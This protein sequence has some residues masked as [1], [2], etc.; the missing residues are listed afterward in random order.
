MNRFTKKFQYSRITSLIFLALFCMMLAPVESRAA[1]LTISPSSAS[2]AIGRSVQFSVAGPGSANVVWSVNGVAGGNATLGTISSSGLYAAPATVPSPAT[3]TI[4]AASANNSGR[5]GQAA[6]TI[7]PGITISISPVNPSVGVSQT[8]QFTATVSGSSNV[9]VIWSVNDVAGGNSTAGTISSSG[10]YTAPATVPSGSVAVTA[11]SAADPTNSTQVSVTVLPA[12]SV[13]I[14]PTSASVGLSQT[15]QFTASVTGS[16]NTTVTWSVNGTA[17][18]NTT[19]G[20]ISSSGLYTAPATMPSS[21]SVTVAATS[22]ADSTKSARAGVT[23]VAS[24]VTVSPSATFVGTGQSVQFTVTQ[25]NSGTTNN[26]GPSQTKYTWSVNGV[27]GG[28][29]KVGTITSKG[30]Y[31][32]PST[33]PNPPTLTITAAASS[34]QGQASATIV[35]VSVTLSP[36]S[37]SV[38]AMQSQQ[39]TATVS[40]VSNTAVTWS[41]NGLA[42]GNSTVGTIS[43]GG[44]YTAPLL[45]PSGAVTVTA[46]SVADATESAQSSVTVLPVVS[47][48]LTPTTASV[49][50]SQ[51]QQFTATVQG[52]SNTSVNWNVNGVAGGNSTVGTISSG[53]LYTAP[54]RVPSPPNVTIAATSIADSTKEASSTVTISPGVAIT[55]SSLPNGQTGSAYSATLA[56]SGGTSPYTWSIASGQLPT[57]VSLSTTTGAI[58]GTPS[59]AGMYNTTF[60]VTDAVGGTATQALSF[61]I[62]ATLSITTTTIPNGTVGMPYSLTLSASGGTAPITWTIISGQLPS[63]LTLSSSGS[64]GGTPTTAGTYNFTAQVQDSSSPQE[65]AS[66]VLTTTMG[67]APITTD[68]YGGYSSMPS[69]NAPTG[70]WRMEKFGTQWWFVDPVNNAFRFVAPYNVGTGGAISQSFL[71]AKYGITAMEGYLP[72]VVARMRSWNYTGFG[73]GSGAFTNAFNQSSATWPFDATLNGY[74][75]P[76]QYRMPSLLYFPTSTYAMSNTIQIFYQRN[77][78]PLDQPPKNFNYGINSYIGTGGYLPGSGEADF[79][80]N[81]L[82]TY[83]DYL[84]MNYQPAQQYWAAPSA[85]RSYVIGALIDE[86]DQMYSFV[87]GGDNASNLTGVEHSHGGLRALRASPLQTANRPRSVIY[88]DST[89]YL[90]AVGLRNYL[91]NKY[92][93]IGAL[94]TAWDST[95]SACDMEG[96]GDEFGSCGTR[97]RDEVFATADGVSATYTH[98]LGQLKPSWHSIAVY[99]SGAMVAGDLGYNSWES[100]IFAVPGTPPPVNSKLYGPLVDGTTST[101]DYSNGASSITF[102]TGSAAVGSISGNGSTVT[103]KT[104]VQHGAWTGAHVNIAG[105]SSYNVSGATIATVVDSYTFTI[106]SSTAASAETSGTVFFTDTTPP[107]GSVITVSYVQDGWGIGNGLMD[108]DG[109]HSNCL[110]ANNDNTNAVTLYL[111]T[112]GAFATQQVAVDLEGFL[113]QMA[114]QYFSNMN[115]VFGTRF[116]N[117]SSRK[118]LNMG[119]DPLIY[120]SSPSHAGVLQAAG[121]YNDVIGVQSYCDPSYCT[122]STMTQAK[123]DWIRQNAGDKPLLNTDFITANPDSALRTYNGNGGFLHFTAQSSR[124]QNYISLMQSLSSLA[125]TNGGSQPYVGTQF[126]QWTDS[127][128]EQSNYGLVTPN[129]NVYDG[130]ESVTN[131]VSCSAPLQTYTCGGEQYI[132]GNFITS[133]A[134]ANSLWFGAV[135]PL[136]VSTSSLLGVVQTNSYSQPL[137]ATG[138][139]IPYTW[140]V[141]SGGL[142]AGLA[143]SSSGVISGTAITPGTSTFTVVVTDAASRTATQTLS[144]LVSPAPTSVTDNFNYANFTYLGTPNWSTKGVT[145]IVVVNHVASPICSGNCAAYWSGPAIFNDD[146]YAEMDIVS[147]GSIGPAVRVDPASIS[148]YACIASSLGEVDL[149]EVNAGTVVSKYSYFGSTSNSNKLRASVSGTS[150]SCLLN[151]VVVVGPVTLTSRSTGLPGIAGTAADASVTAA[152]WDA[153]SN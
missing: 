21:S 34:Q 111:C 144:I 130:N 122:N 2:I 7:I 137:L 49:T 93:T 68:I 66:L 60:R 128:G 74:Y 17:G 147:Q 6:A 104:Q 121:M 61:A 101:I 88:P 115:T 57:G 52:S 117:G 30:A 142:P 114:T 100:D 85:L 106:S 11:T 81:R 20:T 149:I 50:V 67:S 95:Y 77:T 63:G 18:G 110:G 12:V 90:K 44:L 55:T 27:A 79:Y 140:S 135:L 59:T 64:I 107:K 118:V 72:A 150:V 43:T 25:T 138:G 153:G 148:Y 98:V 133:V 123:L 116:G 75:T 32:A 70:N 112:G 129:D 3:I 139:T 80:D 105:T 37:A 9:N 76:T 136:T 96:A 84:I 45:V 46:T 131:V 127:T 23:L 51:T 13:A 48:S 31:T 124:G 4:G 5:S 39:F 1:G 16:S 14:S 10:L 83:F 8:Q 38:P 125:Y 94:N 132:S 141:L 33:P 120:W 109:R 97:I 53:G 89:V 152:N 108:E 71:F 143:L 58:S 126:W 47:V 35:P 99:V 87:T 19:V 103:V 119:P 86:A 28:N 40:N 42:G 24:P 15:Q 54:V 145:G 73:G 22:V 41:V 78:S 56:A 102:K 69:A 91:K 62:A 92:G 134:S 29:S 36:T 26:N 151:N 146:Q 82:Y 113:G 65:T